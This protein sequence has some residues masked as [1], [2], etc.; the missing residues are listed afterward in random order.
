MPHSFDPGYFAEP[1][2][3][4]CMQYPEADVCPA[5]QFRVEWDRFSI[6]GGLAALRAFSSWARIRRSTK[7]SFGAFWSGNRAESYRASR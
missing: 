2:R 5:D 1:F 3:A 4:L 7:P 6:V